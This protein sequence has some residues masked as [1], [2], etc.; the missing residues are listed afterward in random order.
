MDLLLCVIAL[1]GFSA[2]LRFFVV[3][4]IQACQNVNARYNIDLFLV[5]MCDL[6]CNLGINQ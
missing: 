4:R 1:I 2:W 6:L 3:Y 5:C